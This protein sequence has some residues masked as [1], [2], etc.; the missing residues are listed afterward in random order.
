[1]LSFGQATLFRSLE[2]SI[3]VW[4]STLVSQ[5]LEAKIGSL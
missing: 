4:C 2:D 1:M 5:P 3:H